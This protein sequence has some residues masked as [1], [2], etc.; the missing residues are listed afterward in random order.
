MLTLKARKV[1]N[2]KNDAKGI[3]QRIRNGSDCYG[4][5]PCYCLWTK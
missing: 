3:L 4:G 5:V 1:G 2:E